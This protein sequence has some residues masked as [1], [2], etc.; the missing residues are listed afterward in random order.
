MTRRQPTISSLSVL[1]QITRK[2]DG[3]LSQHSHS[4]QIKVC[5]AA[6]NLRV[7][8][9]E[10]QKWNVY[11]EKSWTILIA[12]IFA[13][14]NSNHFSVVIKAI[15]GISA[16]H[17]R[18]WFGPLVTVT[19]IFVERVI[20]WASDGHTFLPSKLLQLT[21]VEIKLKWN[22]FCVIMQYYC[23]AICCEKKRLG[24][25]VCKRHSDLQI[26]ITHSGC[27]DVQPLNSCEE[28]WSIHKCLT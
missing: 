13:N 7:S 10:T 4:L 27:A 20:L 2:L 1:M 18:Q 16:M 9:A 12:Q 21:S 3:T 11:F 26:L 28:F 22:T 8:S 23:W 5:F 14:L 19:H 6:N 25:V 17:C 15:Q 24:F